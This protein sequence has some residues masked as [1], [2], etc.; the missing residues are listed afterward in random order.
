M[1]ILAGRCLSPMERRA[2]AHALFQRLST[3]CSSL[4]LLSEE[5]D[6]KKTPA[7]IFRKPSLRSDS[8][9]PL[10]IFHNL[11][12]PVIMGVSSEE[13]ELQNGTT[14][15]CLSFEDEFDFA[16]RLYYACIYFLAEI[17][18]LQQFLNSCNL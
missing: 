8:V 1:F 17:F 16:S 6:A 14:S 3:V 13:K 5:Y 15:F 12:A 9:T 2:Q 18:R 11:T 7:A 4:G 10:G